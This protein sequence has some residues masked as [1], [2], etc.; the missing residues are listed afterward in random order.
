VHQ[1]HSSEY[2]NPFDLPEGPVLVVGAGP[3]G[4]QLALELARF[5]KVWLSGPDTGHL[6]RRLLGRDIFD[7]LWPLFRGATLATRRGR[8][9]RQRARRGGDVLIGIPEA[10]LQ[11][12]GVTRVPRLDGLRAGWPLCGDQLLQPRVVLWCTG[13][14][15][16]YSWIDL[17]IFEPDGSPRHV[18]GVASA[19]PGLY[20]LGL[21]YQYRMTSSLIGGVGDDAAHLA[22][23][24]AAFDR[25]TA[26]HD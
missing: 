2:R 9:L 17:D 16:D 15:V 22:D 6:P 23:R 11:A 12:A 3:S 14:R 24:I 4:A 7:W 1:C 8:T 26:M 20:F 21:R 18:R 19:C 10:T 5:R 13:F 25:H